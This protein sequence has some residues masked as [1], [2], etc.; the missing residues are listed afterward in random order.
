MLKKQKIIRVRVRVSNEEVE[1]EITKL[2]CYYD[3]D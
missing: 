2:Q 1:D 3:Y